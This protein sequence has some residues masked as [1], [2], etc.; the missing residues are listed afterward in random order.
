VTYQGY[1]R[2][3]ILPRWEAYTL[4]RINAGEVELWLRSLPFSPFQLRQDQESYE[5]DI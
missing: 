4:V 2:K 3:W 1:L 5:R